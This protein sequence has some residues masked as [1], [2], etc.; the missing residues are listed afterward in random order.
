MAPPIPILL[1]GSTLGPAEKRADP[2]TIERY[3]SN[4]SNAAADCARR[5]R[6]MNSA[7]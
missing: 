6:L 1:A 7:R 4:G 2:A 3:W 5:T